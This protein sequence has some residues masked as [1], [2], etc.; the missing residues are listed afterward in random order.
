MKA[1][2]FFNYPYVFCAQEQAF[3]EI[4]Q[5]VGRRGAF[6]MQSDLEDFEKQLA[7][8]TGAKYAIGVAKPV[9]LMVDTF[10]TGKMPENEIV[11]KIR[12]NFDLTPK[13]IIAMLNL[14]R[15]IY[16][17]TAAYGHFGRTGDGF[18]W[19]KTDKVNELV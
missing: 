19:E 6:I 9:S 4:T 8:Y 16:L 1:I 12:Q 10:G 14:R 11:E 18:T 17:K 7:N 15:P 2:A 5:K 3:L 13:G